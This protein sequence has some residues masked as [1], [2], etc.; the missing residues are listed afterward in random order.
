MIKK[1]PVPLA[2]LLLLFVIML[3]GWGNYY[4]L[5]KDAEMLSIAAK[6]VQ[7]S[8]ENS[9]WDDAQ[10]HLD[11]TLKAWKKS[12]KYWPML[13]HHQEMDR[14]EES[15]N[16]IKSYLENQDSSLSQAELYNLIFYIKHIPEKE[17]LNLKNVF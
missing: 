3:A 12:S 13:V 10:V 9:N 6:K 5:N 11:E 4:L 14:I 2:L 15:M 8:V 17:S 16:K 7:K 1:H